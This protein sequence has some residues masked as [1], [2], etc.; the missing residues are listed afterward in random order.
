MSKPERNSR[1]LAKGEPEDTPYETLED[2]DDATALP[3]V[4]ASKTPDERTTKANTHASSSIS[5]PVVK[6]TPTPAAQL[7][8]STTRITKQ[9]IESMIAAAQE[10]TAQDIISEKCRV[11][12]MS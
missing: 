8:S 2:L 4:E 10:R 9:D 3:E 11:N 12:R 1:R 7:R 5:T 6:P